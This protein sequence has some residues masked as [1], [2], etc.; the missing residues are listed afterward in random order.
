MLDFGLHLKH[1]ILCKTQPVKLITFIT[2]QAKITSQKC[3]NEA[4]SGSGVKGTIAQGTNRDRQSLWIN[5]F[6]NVLLKS[7]LKRLL[8]IEFSGVGSQGYGW[9]LLC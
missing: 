1:T 2:L 8:A 5:G 4:L 9:N 3:W 7:C 6:W